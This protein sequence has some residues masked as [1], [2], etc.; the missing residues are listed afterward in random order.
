MTTTAAPTETPART[1]RE[2]VRAE[3]TDEIKA[4]ARRQLATQ[5]SSGLSL[6]AVARE[7]GLV[8][9][10]VY[11]YFPSRDALLTSLIIDSYASLGEAAENAEARV[12]RSGVGKRWHAI[13]HAVHDWAL[14]HPHEYALIY[15]SPI[16]GYEA[17]QDTIAPGT[18]IPMLLTGLFADVIAARERR[19]DEQHA[20][21]RRVH[22]AIA[23]LREL[24]PDVVPDDLI[25]S[26]MMAWTYL[27]GAVSFEVFGQRHNAFS[28]DAAF[29]DYEIT[30][31]AEALGLTD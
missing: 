14:A 28:D 6:R 26:G 23:P 10:A 7:V 19:G 2:R 21:P 20:V 29:F 12:H 27:F 16:P 18:R 24:V 13:S 15:G 3:M 4:A 30:R 9:S 1:A 17:P 5:G 11:R 31:I 22:R 25:V 8:S